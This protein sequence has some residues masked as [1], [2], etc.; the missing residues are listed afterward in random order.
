MAEQDR[1]YYRVN[2]G[3]ALA[4]IETFCADQQAVADSWRAFAAKHGAKLYRHDLSLRGLIFD[5][6]PPEGWFPAVVFPSNVCVPNRRTKLGRE[7]AEN[8]SSLPRKLSGRDLAAR[9][10]GGE[11]LLRAA[12]KLMWPGFEKIGNAYVL[13]MPI[14]ED[15]SHCAPPPDCTQLK[16]SEYWAL[17]EAVEEAKMAPAGAA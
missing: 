6:D 3:E 12:G 4:I 9:L 11:A 7:I 16:M 2:G 17:K 1:I 15:G 8:L 5:G 10:G 14:D 13:S